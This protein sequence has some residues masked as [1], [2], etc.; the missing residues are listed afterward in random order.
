VNEPAMSVNLLYSYQR[1]IGGGRLIAEA[2][3]QLG[4]VTSPTLVRKHRVFGRIG[5]IRAVVAGGTGGPVSSPPSTA[6]SSRGWSV[7][8]SCV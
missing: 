7:L 2:E 6:G 5:E 8:G 1:L 3:L 4:A